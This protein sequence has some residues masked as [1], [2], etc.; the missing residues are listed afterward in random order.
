MPRTALGAVNNGLADSRFHAAAS[1]VLTH[2]R[3]KV[4]MNVHELKAVLKAHD[5]AAL[6]LVLPSGQQIPD[7]FHVTEVG[8]VEKDF[9]DC[10]GTRRQS[11][12][13]QLQAWVAHDVDHRLAAGKLAKILQLAEPVLGSGELPVE[14]EYG[15][16]V[17]AQ[18]QLAEVQVAVD[19][20]YFVL[21]G[22]QTDCLAKDKC[23]VGECSDSSCCC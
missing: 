7:H 19:G 10:G 11:V 17:A 1:L 3:K 20:L 15:V 16:D 9:I 21:V 12:A 6:R 22:K 2:N 18:Y 13:C 23:G 14:I 4:N 8:R 5:Q